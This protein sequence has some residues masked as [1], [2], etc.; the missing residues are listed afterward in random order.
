MY[1]RFD[2]V[3]SNSPFI[4]KKVLVVCEEYS[5]TDDYFKRNELAHLKDRTAAYSFCVRY[6][7][8]HRIRKIFFNDQL[9]DEIYKLS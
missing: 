8:A 2:L 6:A 5:E 1:Y 4:T 7:R 3:L 9:G